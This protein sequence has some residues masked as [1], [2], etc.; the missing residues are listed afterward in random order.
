MIKH[1]T[2][3][4]AIMLRWLTGDGI[5][6]LTGFL[7]FT[8]SL[9]IFAEI[10]GEVVEGDTLAFDRAVLEAL[11]EPD[12]LSDPLGPNWVEE[13]VRDVTALGSSAL[14]TLFSVFAVGFLILERKPKTIAFLVL[15]VVGGLV[16]SLW[17][18]GIF[19]RPRPDFLTHGQVVYTKSF[20][21]GHSMNAAVVYLTLG[22]ILA[23][24]HQARAI[25]IYVL[26]SSILLAV[27]VGLSR[28]YLGV[29]WPS[30]V[31]AGWS[32]GAGWA[33]LCYLFIHHLQRRHMIE[34]E[35]GVADNT[36]GGNVT[37][38]GSIAT[39]DHARPSSD[40]RHH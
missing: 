15:A 2:D 21:S 1:F 25:K 30:D 31:L 18:K 35:T 28:L 36:A 34:Q 20:P 38:R 26:A 24:A 22:S 33:V 16:L 8:I 39:S 9:W 27:L 14:L 6:Y 5:H 7:F 29:H 32:A 11:R 12:D 17:L 3:R 4:C 10:A 37:P 40:N 13:A 23:R 19:D